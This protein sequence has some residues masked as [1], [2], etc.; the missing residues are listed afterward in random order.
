MKEPYEPTGRPGVLRK[1]FFYSGALLGIIIWGVLFLL[2]T[3]SRFHLQPSP[4]QI[5]KYLKDSPTLLYDNRK[6]AVGPRLNVSSFRDGLFRP[7][8]TSVQWIHDRTADGKYVLTHE[9]SHVIKSIVD[10]SYEYVL[11]NATGFEYDGTTY[12]VE[13]LMASPD[14]TQA[15]LQTN[16]THNWRHSS[17][18]LYWHLDVATQKIEPV[19]SE[20]LAVTSWSPKSDSVAFVYNNDVYIKRPDGVVRVT[21][22]G[23]ANVF[24]GKPDWVYEEEVFASDIVLWWSPDGDKIAFLKLNDTEVPEYPIQYYVQDDRDYPEVRNIKYPK[25]GY[26]NPIVELVVLEVDD[27]K[28]ASS[29][30]LSSMVEYLITEVLW[31]SDDRVLV[32]TS[33]RA[34]DRLEIYLVDATKK[35]AQLVRTHK[36]EKSWF[37]VLTNTHFVPKD[38]SASRGHDGYI[39]TVVVDGFNHLAYFSPPQNPEPVLLTSGQWEVVDGV[40]AFDEETN[41]V[42]FI[43]TKKS[44]VERH[45]YTVNLHS[46]QSSIEEIT[47]TS[48]DGWY[49]ASIS[50]GSRYL[51][52]TNG[53]PRVPYQELVDLHTRKHLKT[54]ESNEKLKETMETHQVPRVEYLVVSLGTDEQGRDILA[55]VKETFPLNFDRSR[56]YPVLF[57]VYGG[58]G[59]QMVTKAFSV[60][61]SALAAAELDAVV[62]TVDGRGTGFNSYADSDFKFCVRD[63]L[64]HYEPIDQIAAAKIWSK[65]SYVDASRMAI[66][67]W[68]YGGFLTLKTLE[69]DGGSVF[70][71]G[72]AVAP[73]TKWKLYDSIYT[74]RYMRTPQENPEGYVTASIHNATQFKD[75]TRFLI[76]HGSGDDNVHF[77]NT[78]ELIDEYNLAAVENFDF[79]VFPDSDHSI[80][81]HN[82]NNVVFDRLFSWLDRAFGGEFLMM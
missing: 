26:P 32:K 7:D 16:V 29:V 78:L 38:I 39:D 34:S 61:T 73:V 35:S 56:Q 63:Q 48:R 33:N 59:S 27:V 43:A 12:N 60:D 55:N 57:Y 64:G 81:Y 30:P 6:Q 37:E 25:A 46:G 21:Y 18:A 77:Q 14:L 19:F 41:Q 42:Y 11:F 74:E 40:K 5:Q 62:V 44:S 52:S 80:S 8:F 69:T 4:A 79:M 31:V 3:I 10:D 9:S 65:K 45:L 71:Y 23:D 36:A 66:W 82:G 47:D 76:M 72:A 15:L 51:L 1:R 70:S 53:G 49:S 13:G 24:N 54:I 68:S 2:M 20:P 28:S 58:P 17:F 22:D 50:S 67:G 75:V